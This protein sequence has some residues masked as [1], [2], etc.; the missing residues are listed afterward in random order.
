MPGYRA[1]FFNKKAALHSIEILA[2]AAKQPAFT[3]R[4]V[5]THFAQQLSTYGDVSHE[6]SERLRKLLKSGMIMI[7]DEGA[8]KSLVSTDIIKDKEA[9]AL[10]ARLAAIQGSGED[11]APKARGRKA[12]LYRLT[13]AGEN[14]VK[15]RKDTLKFIDEQRKAG[16]EK[17]LIAPDE[18]QGPGKK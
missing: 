13:I 4:E 5:A 12:R 3:S 14:H 11:D 7:L 1:S 10:L 17:P 16:T 15:E 18:Q 9:P 2:W 6:V 8:V